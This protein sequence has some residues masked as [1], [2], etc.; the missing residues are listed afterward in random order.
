[1]NA[2]KTRKPAELRVE[3]L[4]AGRRDLVAIYRRRWCIQ[5]ISEVREVK[6]QVFR[7]GV[8]KCAEHGLTQRCSHSIQLRKTCDE[9]GMWN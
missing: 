2:T 3:T 8:N 9:Y 7:N 5:V 4:K 1:M 6:V